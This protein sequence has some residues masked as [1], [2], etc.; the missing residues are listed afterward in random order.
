[1]PAPSRR[2]VLK[3]I[4]LIGLGTLAATRRGLSLA[5]AQSDSIPA[6]PPRWNGQPLGR[7][8]GKTMNVRAE[9]STD[10][11]VVAVLERDDVVR[12]RRAVHGE[13]T[14]P[15]ND[16]WLETPRGYLY[17]SFV[18]PMWYHLPNPPRADLGNGRWAEL[19]VPYSN[20]YWDPE[21]NEDRFVSRQHYGSVYRIEELVTG[22][23]GKSWYRVRELYQSY[24]MR[25]THLRIIP[26]EELTPISPEVDPHEKRIEVNLA[27]QTLIAYEGERP[28]FAHLISSGIPDY[29]T[30]EGEH[31][32][33]D[34]RISTRM[35]GG[36]ASDEEEYYN[37]PGV[38]FVCYFTWE[39]AATHGT[40]WHNDYGRPRS[41]GCLNLPPDAARWIWRW[42]TPYADY[43]SLYFRP[44]TRSEG[45]RII[46]Y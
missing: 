12:V 41:H 45:T 3:S 28:V 21:P 37:L 36:A 14:F 1:M 5:R 35:I 8:T 39:W 15:N 20:A 25:A 4:G 7:I 23:D 46:I 13:A 24:Y 19:T 10:S 26:P 43:D 40:Y 22:G 6:L 30:P 11:E 9:P 38:P 27:T 42:T 16:L 18:Q 32:V 29:A 2:T 34:K 33:V 44:R 31:R 17:A